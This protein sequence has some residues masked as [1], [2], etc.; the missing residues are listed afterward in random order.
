[1]CPVSHR[2]PLALQESRCGRSA[3]GTS[4]F[5]LRPSWVSVSWVSCVAPTAGCRTPLPTTDERAVPEHTETICAW[6]RC[7]TP[8]R[9]GCSVLDRESLPLTSTPKDWLSPI[10]LLSP[11][12]LCCWRGVY[13]APGPGERLSRGQHMLNATPRGCSKDNGWNKKRRLLD[14]QQAPEYKRA[15]WRRPTSPKDPTC[16][17]NDCLH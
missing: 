3:R 15:S 2:M 17:E 5:A 13:A 6:S 14:L 11:N 12:G 7:S 9:A 10:D 1:M 16:A 8:G 4:R